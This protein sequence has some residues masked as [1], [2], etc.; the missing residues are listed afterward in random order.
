MATLRV[1]SASRF[2]RLE[3][4]ELGD[5]AHDVVPESV[6]QL[7]GEGCEHLVPRTDFLGEGLHVASGP[8]QLATGELTALADEFSRRYTRQL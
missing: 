5:L 8:V 1:A 2:E 3:V 6:L 7:V 4:G